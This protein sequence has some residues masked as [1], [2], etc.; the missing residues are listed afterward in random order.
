MLGEVLLESPLVGVVER[1]KGL[2]VVSQQ[3][4]N[5]LGE[6]IENPIFLE[7]FL[8]QPNQRLHELEPDESSLRIEGI[9]LPIWSRHGVG[10]DEGE[11]GDFEGRVF[12]DDLGLLAELSEGLVGYCPDVSKGIPGGKLFVDCFDVCVVGPKKSLHFVLVGLV[13]NQVHYLGVLPVPLKTLLQ[14]LLI[15]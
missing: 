8:G 12:V 1:N 5:T 13:L 4:L 9:S 15:V 6:V 11:V 7:L 14:Q 2:E 10:G 3:G